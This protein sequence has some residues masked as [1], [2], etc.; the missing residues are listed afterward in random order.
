L[1]RW[2]SHRGVRKSCDENTMQAFQNAK[3]RGFVHFETDLRTT[4][5]G[6][7][8]MHHD[9]QIFAASGSLTTVAS[10]SF[11]QVRDLRLRQGGQIPRWEE[12][13]EA[14]A[15][16]D[17]TLDVKKE[18]GIEVIQTLY[19][20]SKV[21]PSHLEHLMYRTRFLLWDVSHDQLLHSLFEGAKCYARKEQCIR[22]GIAVIAG[23]PVFAGI[24]PDLIYSIPPSFVGISGF[25]RIYVEAFHR[26]GAKVVAYL[27]DTIEM[28]RTAID[29]GF[30]EILSDG[31]IFRQAG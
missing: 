1:H 4:A 29:C 16:V 20:W 11:A 19:N 18:T 13:A 7:I 9:P 15:D 6:I 24:N 17:W 25:R 2:I 3:D 31:I 8:V 28:C 14:H 10:S 21:R 30:D 22:A 23:L 27:P 12:F 26:R 5:D